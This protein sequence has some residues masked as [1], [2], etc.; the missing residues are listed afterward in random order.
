MKRITAL[1]LVLVLAMLFLT[2]CGGESASAD[3]GSGGTSWPEKDI[4]INV[5]YTAGGTADTANRTLAA[6]MGE[7]L[8]V[9]VNIVNVTGGSGSIAGMQVLGAAHDGYTWLG[10]VAHTASGWRIMDYADAS[11][12]DFYGFYGATAPYVLFVSKDSPYTTY[13]ELFDAMAADPTIKWGNAGLGSIN[14]LTAQQMMDIMGLQGVTVPYG[15]GREA[16]IKVIANE[17]VWSWCGISD[18]MDLA[19]SG[20]IRI[21]GVCDADPMQVDAATGAYEAPSLLTDYPE[22]ESLENL[23]YWGFRVP[24]DTPAEVVGRIEEA[25]LYAVDTEEWAQYCA[26]NALTPSTTYGTE[27]DEMCARLE[28]IYVWGLYDQG[29]NAEGVTPEDLGIPTLDEFTY[30]TNDRIA[31]ITPWPE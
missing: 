24:R 2:G 14:Q 6:I 27:S 10:D 18:I 19:L 11:W 20:D 23:L 13:Q 4:T 26:E 22:L 29:L 12:E 31:A 1:A 9:N 3:S 25:F 5:A 17:V 15:G 21:L 28:S 8:G 7:Y 30:P 16:A